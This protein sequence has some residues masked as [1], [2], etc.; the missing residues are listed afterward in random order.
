MSKPQQFFGILSIITDL[1]ATV[2]LE[3]IPSLRTEYY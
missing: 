3:Q 1:A 2:T